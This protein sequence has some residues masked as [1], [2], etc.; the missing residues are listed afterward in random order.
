MILDDA[1]ALVE[2]DP[3]HRVLRR[4][5]PRSHY[6]D[7]GPLPEFNGIYLDCETTGTDTKKDGILELAMQ[8]FK[9]T[10][11][12]R[13]TTLSEPYMSLNDPGIKLSDDIRRITGIAPEDIVGQSLDIVTIEQMVSGADLV[14]AHNADFDR[15]M[16]ERPLP[17]FV[18]KPWG[19]SQKDV[20]WRAHFHAIG[21]GL[22]ILA[23]SKC[24]VFYP[25][26]RALIDCQVG[27]HVLATVVDNDGRTAFSHL[28]QGVMS[29]SLRIWATGAPFET[30]DTLKN[31]GY[32]WNDGSDGRFKAWHTKV[33]PEKLEEENQ[34]L[35]VNA[36]AYPRVTETTAMDR[37]SVREQ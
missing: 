25:A 14:I 29:E 16:I 13:I 2:A 15:R 7:P 8:P 27:I 5:V 12:G 4:F 18:Q 10:E 23:M 17:I 36:G 33:S 1:I 37:Y 21:E 31:R 9:Y 26:H 28:L 3:N 20:A 19:C 6:N 34:W 35:R 30:K 22:E 11:D 32:R 24:G